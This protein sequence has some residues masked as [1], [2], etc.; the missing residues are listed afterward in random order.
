MAGGFTA[1]HRGGHGSPL[2]AIHGFTDTWRTWEL[3]LPALEREHDVLAPTLPGHAGGPALPEALTDTTLVEGVEAAIDAAGFETAHVVGNSLGGYVALQLATRGR[4][5]SVVAFAPAGGWMETGRANRAVF[6]HF[7]MML[8]GLARALP[9]LDA[10]LSTTEGRRTATQFSAENFEHIPVELIAHQMVGAV[11]CTGA[12]ALI[13]H[14]IS[15]GWAPATV[16][17]PQC[18][19]RIVWGEEDRLLR[20][21]DAAARYRAGDGPLARADWV[22]LP[23]VGHCPQLDVPAVA[24]EL[25]LEFTR[26]AGA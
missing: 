24:A 7:G 1:A 15:P 23:G 20:W 26:R 9:G 3:I 25:V 12:R 22:T 4:A 19:V 5:R 18:P 21:P 11:E 16:D 8:E 6:A 2:V 17:A 13:S 10:L 14:G